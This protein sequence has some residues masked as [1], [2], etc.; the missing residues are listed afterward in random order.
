MDVVIGHKGKRS[1]K[2]IVRGRTCH[3]SL[4]RWA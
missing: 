4:A 3:S 1:F 2:V